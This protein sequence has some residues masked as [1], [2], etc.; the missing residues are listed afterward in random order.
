MVS[1]SAFN[2][3]QGGPMHLRPQENRTAAELALNCDRKPIKPAMP[4]PYLSRFI[5]QYC[6]LFFD[7]LC[8]LLTVAEDV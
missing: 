4:P 3:D 8:M 2:V 5:L 1:H 6:I 7:H